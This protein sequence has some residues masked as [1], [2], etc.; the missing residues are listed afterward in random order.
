MITRN[1]HK[2]RDRDKNSATGHQRASGAMCMIAGGEQG[3]VAAPR[4]R[5]LR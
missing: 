4:S 5:H 1:V 2:R 3:R